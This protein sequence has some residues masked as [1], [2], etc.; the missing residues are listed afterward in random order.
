M[1]KGAQNGLHECHADASNASRSGIS[2]PSSPTGHGHAPV[3]AWI[4]WRCKGPVRSI[5]YSSIIV[6]SKTNKQTNERPK[7]QRTNNKLFLTILLHTYTTTSTTQTQMTKQ[8][9]KTTLCWISLSFSNNLPYNSYPHKCPV[10]LYLAIFLF[11][12]NVN[13]CKQKVGKG[14][15]YQT[16]LRYLFYLS[17]IDFFCFSIWRTNLVFLRVCLGN[18]GYGLNS[19]YFKGGFF[20]KYIMFF[21]IFSN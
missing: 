4:P 17:S 13:L 12:I 3:W 20:S 16:Q 18:Y 15:I 19:G 1:E 10:E 5:Q 21:V 2:A 14:Y 8:K 9:E 6:M 7:L 11:V